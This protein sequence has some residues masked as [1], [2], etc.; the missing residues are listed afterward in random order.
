MTPRIPPIPEAEWDEPTRALIQMPWFADRPTKGQNFF[1]T[2]VRHPELFG[3]WNEFGRTLFNGRLSERDRELLV[4]R[5]AW[6]AQCEFVWAQ[7]QPVAEQL[8]MALHEIER[9]VEGADAGWSDREAALLRAVDQLHAHADI[10]DNTW[11][12]LR[13]HYDDFELIEIPVVVGQYLLIAFFN[14]A[15]RVEPDPSLPRLP[16]RA[17]TKGQA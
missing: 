10:D 5:I 2:F 11:T 16:G 4:L 9:I 3:A 14:N 8:G 7:H 17:R 6:L 12:T 15:L 1:Q 13:A